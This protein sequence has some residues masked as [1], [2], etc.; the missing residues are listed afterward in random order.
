MPMKQYLLFAWYSYY[1]LW[2]ASDFQWDFDTLEECETKFEEIKKSD[3]SY[4]YNIIDIKN[5][6]IKYC[7]Y[8]NFTKLKS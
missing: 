4:W 8:K 1:P 2:W 7:W 5:N 6:K 3:T